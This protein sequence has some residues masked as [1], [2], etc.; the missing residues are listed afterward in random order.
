MASS[1]PLCLSGLSG[2]PHPAPLGS[3][4]GGGDHALELL[5]DCLSGLGQ[6]LLVGA[7]LGVLLELLDDLL[8]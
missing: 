7:G 4:V 1:H 8:G 2:L 3:G 6:E 5:E